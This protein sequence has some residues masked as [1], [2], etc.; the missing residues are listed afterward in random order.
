MML[1]LPAPRR[2]LVGPC[3]SAYTQG[4]AALFN[5]TTSFLERADITVFN[6]ASTNAFS[7]WVYLTSKATTQC[8]LGKY[9]NGGGLANEW[10]LYYHQPLDRMRLD[11]YTSTSSIGAT[12]NTFGSPPTAT[13][14]HVWCWYAGPGPSI[15][16]NDGAVDTGSLT[17]TKRTSQ[18][19]FRLGR[20][21]DDQ[22]PLSG[23]LA[24]VGRWTSVPA[25]TERTSI[26][27]GGVRKTY[28][29]LSAAEKTNLTSF[30]PLREV[31]GVT[32]YCDYHGANHLAA[33]A[34]AQADG[35]P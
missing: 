23:R 12:A 32:D 35:P 22:W 25:G 1:W 3:G 20:T 7:V 11:L 26:Y 4:K 31:N 30:Y 29:A 6:G 28:E 15:S 2:G 34:M 27:N 16:V 19:N 17:G 13:W 14:F 5:G 10:V 9:S 18:R 24:D 33:T 21:E 8:I